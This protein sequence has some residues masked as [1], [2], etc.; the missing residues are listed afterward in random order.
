MCSLQ[1]RRQAEQGDETNRVEEFF[2]ELRGAVAAAAAVTAAA[3]TAAGGSRRLGPARSAL[4]ASFSWDKLPGLLAL[5]GIGVVR[6]LATGKKADATDDAHTLITFPQASVPD[7][8]RQGA[9]LD[10]AVRIGA[11]P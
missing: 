2:P 8:T 1:H 5:L 9:R 6:D 11:L 10:P 3:A 7:D 4:P